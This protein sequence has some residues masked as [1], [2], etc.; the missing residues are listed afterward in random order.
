[1]RRLLCLIGLV[2]VAFTAGA[3]YRTSSP[4]PVWLEESFQDGKYSYLEV[5]SAVG[6]DEGNAR[7]KALQ[8]IIVR[9]DF[10]TGARGQVRM[11]G[12]RIVVTGGGDVTV[13]ARVLDEYTEHLSPGQWRVSLF[14]QT[15]K[16]PEYPF[17]NVSI[18]DKYPASA[19][20]FIPGMAQ[21]HKGSKGKGIAFI[22]AEVAFAGG[23]VF[24]EMSRQSNMNLINTTQNADNMLAYMNR[25]Q[26]CATV[27]NIC[28]AG[29]AAVYVWNVVDGLAARGKTHIAVGD[30]ASLDMNPY[31]DNRSAGLSFALN[32]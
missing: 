14:V 7:D 22:A 4:R 19:M 24:A 30:F 3:Q 23:I 5:V 9:R 10:S 18:T 26:N 27:R 20:A 11:D 13:K 2:L 21:I 29:A 31:M 12:D 8:M 28:I 15:A 25:A 16:H 32:F 17:E 6:Y 1:M